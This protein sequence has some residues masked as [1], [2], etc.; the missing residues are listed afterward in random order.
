MYCDIVDGVRKYSLGWK[1][2]KQNNSSF[3]SISILAPGLNK[4]RTLPKVTVVDK[5]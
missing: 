2:K 4:G 5:Q 1:I 3:V